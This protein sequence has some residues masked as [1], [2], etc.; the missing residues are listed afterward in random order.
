MKINLSVGQCEQGVPVHVYTAG[1]GSPTLELSLELVVILHIHL[2][3]VYMHVH[4]PGIRMLPWWSPVL[5]DI[6][7][8]TSAA[9]QSPCGLCTAQVS[10]FMYM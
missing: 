6:L 1:H 2:Y 9:R 5:T 10:G 7:L 4:T 8:F 3:I